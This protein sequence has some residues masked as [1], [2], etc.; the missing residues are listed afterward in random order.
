MNVSSPP[1]LSRKR[2][3]YVVEGLA[4]LRKAQRKPGFSGCG[5]FVALL[6]SVDR[7]KVTSSRLMLGE[8]VN[9]IHFFG[10][11]HTALLLKQGLDSRFWPRLCLR[12][13]IGDPNVRHDSSNSPIALQHEL[14]P[15]FIE[16]TPSSAQ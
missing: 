4:R 8:R 11:H 15:H 9:L 5:Q 6:L 13:K 12:A 1:S 10:S 3:M 14:P 16:S 7:V 2:C